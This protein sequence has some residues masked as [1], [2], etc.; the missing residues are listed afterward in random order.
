[1]KV[2]VVKVLLPIALPEVKST[3]AV[4]FVRPLRHFEMEQ[5]HRSMLMF[6]HGPAR[7]QSLR[8]EADD[9][10]CNIVT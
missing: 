2:R 4:D 7:E 3:N 9:K 1:M 10:V 8:A 6:L 5:H